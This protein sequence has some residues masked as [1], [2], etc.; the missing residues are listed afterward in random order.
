MESTGFYRRPLPEGLIAFSS[1]EGRQ[2]FREALGE[3]GM[4]GYFALA[5]QLH[6]QADPAFCGLATLVVVLN[7]LA[8]DPGRLW[9]GPWRWY[10]EELLDC[11]RPLDAVRRE[12]VTM[13]QFACLARCNGARARM[14]AAEGSTLSE[15]RYHV[16]GACSQAG[17]AHVVAAYAR[18][19]LGQTGDGHYSPIG[20]YHRGRDLALVM[21]VARFKY[22]PHWVSLQVLWDAMQPADPVTARPRGY[23]VLSRGAG[24][25]RLVCAAPEEPEAW[26]RLERAF[27][28]ALR[29]AA[30]GEGAGSLEALVGALLPRLPG[31]AWRVIPERDQSGLALFEEVRATPAYGLVQGALARSSARGRGEGIPPELATILLL[32]LPRDLWS[33]A[34]GDVAGELEGLRSP[35]ALPPGLKAEVARVSAQIGALDDYCHGRL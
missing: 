7:A 5:E 32:S 31:D 23:F 28:E 30:A 3:G 20:G 15:L 29:E 6:T 4:E 21:D 12:G 35:D 18:G 27:I 10:G 8:I 19:A 1:D 26:E 9:R 33:M 34:P 2:I 25:V 11:C 16:R 13:D 17:G 24:G 22:P 14:Y